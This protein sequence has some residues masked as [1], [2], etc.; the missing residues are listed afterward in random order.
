MTNPCH[1]NDTIDTH[2]PFL[3]EHL[4]CLDPEDARSLST[5]SSLLCFDELLR[6]GEADTDEPDGDGETSTDPEDGLPALD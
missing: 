2:P 5:F 4:L 3:L 1:E 6:F